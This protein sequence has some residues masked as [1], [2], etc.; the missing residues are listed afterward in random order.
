MALA[1][2]GSTS[3]LASAGTLTT[4]TLTTANGRGIIVFAFWSNTA[5]AT[6]PSASGLTF[7]NRVTGSNGTGLSFYY[8]YTAPYTSNF[9]GTITCT[10][11][12]S[13]GRAVA[14]GISGTP[15][16]NIYDSHSGLPVVSG[17][18]SGT[19][20]TTSPN[21]FIMEIVGCSATGVPGGSWVLINN[22][23]PLTAAYQIVST[24]QTALA[25]S[26]TNGVGGSVLDAIVL[27]PAAYP[28]TN[29]V[30]T[31]KGFNK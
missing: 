25:L 24:P 26:C 29:I 2:D 15:T 10:A 17:G 14:F 16:S 19:I 12:T 27:A 21:T 20:S 4:G 18:A 7:T 1:L 31:F 11:S 23:N 22:T 13:T 5:I 3:G 8:T 30:R 6:G 9:S 28:R